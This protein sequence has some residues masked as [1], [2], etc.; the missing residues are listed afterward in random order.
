MGRNPEYKVSFLSDLVNQ[1]KSEIYNT[2]DSIQVEGLSTVWE[3][4]SELIETVQQISDKCDV[5]ALLIKPTCEIKPD[6]IHIPK[7]EQIVQ[8]DTKL[9]AAIER[10]D[11]AIAMRNFL[12][13]EPD[14]GEEF[15]RYVIRVQII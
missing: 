2:F 1:S 11:K 15:V 12:L 13:S 5:W 10:K 4:R 8:D 6:M 3:K 14:I 7:M 9:K